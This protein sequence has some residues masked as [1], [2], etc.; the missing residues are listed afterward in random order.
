[1]KMVL[2]ILFLCLMVSNA[3]AGEPENKKFNGGGF[4]TGWAAAWGVPMFGFGYCIC[5]EAKKDLAKEGCYS[6]YWRRSVKKQ[7]LIGKS[8]KG[9]GA[10]LIIVPALVNNRR[11]LMDGVYNRIKSE[12]RRE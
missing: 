5:Y 8:L 6:A 1:M 10:G 11:L 2:A 4:F 12:N 7:L 9:A 3:Q